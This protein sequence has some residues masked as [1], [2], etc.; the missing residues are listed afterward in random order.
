MQGTSPG[1]FFF[2]CLD[3]NPIRTV[4]QIGGSN[5]VWLEKL[6]V[7]AGVEAV[8]FV[9]MKSATVPQN[10]DASQ[11][12]LHKLA[13]VQ[14][15]N[16]VHVAILKS[17]TRTTTTSRTTTATTTITTTAIL[18]Q[19]DRQQQQQHQEQQPPLQPLGQQMSRPSFE[20]KVGMKRVCLSVRAKLEDLKPC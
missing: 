2:T 1:K 9:R 17:C 15:R 5:R 16:I 3:S 14:T 8:I 7:S 20:T 18:Q 13:A 4:E 6:I 10:P 12:D 11:H 19:H